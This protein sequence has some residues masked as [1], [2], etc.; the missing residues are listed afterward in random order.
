MCALSIGGATSE[1]NSEENV[2]ENKSEIDRAPPRIPENAS[3]L[4]NM[5]IDLPD[6]FVT[7]SRQASPAQTPLSVSSDLKLQK[8]PM[9][10]YQ[11][12]RTG[13]ERDWLG[14]C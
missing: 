2:A 12:F 5:E 14:S 3:N 1:N 10:P 8:R 9:N 4:E 13:F 11:C 6:F 7:T